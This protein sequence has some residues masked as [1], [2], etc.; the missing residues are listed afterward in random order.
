MGSAERSVSRVYHCYVEKGDAHEEEPPF[1][2]QCCVLSARFEEGKVRYRTQEYTQT[3]DK[4]T[5][6]SW[7]SASL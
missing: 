6:I 7:S 3:C 4:F 2:V 1:G 5:Y